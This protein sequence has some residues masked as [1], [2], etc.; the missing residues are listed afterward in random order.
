M[1]NERAFKNA[2]KTI[3]FLAGE[4]LT[5]QEANEAVLMAKAIFR[6]LQEAAVEKQKKTALADITRAAEISLTQ[7]GTLDVEAPSTPM[8]SGEFEGIMRDYTKTGKSRTQEHRNLN[9]TVLAIPENCQSIFV[10]ADGNL[11]DERVK[12]GLTPL[13]DDRDRE[14]ETSVPCF[15]GYAPNP[16]PKCLDTLAGLQTAKQDEAQSADPHSHEAL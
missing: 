10:C 16:N 5:L 12:S 9:W 13:H 6:G 11:F 7:E 14:S 15:I 3:D 2:Q 4:G 8:T 1:N